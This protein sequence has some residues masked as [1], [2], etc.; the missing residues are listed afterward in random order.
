MGR[1]Y[2]LSL[3]GCLSLATSLLGATA[4]RA[5]SAQEF[6]AKHS[7][8]MIVGTDVGGSFDLMGRLTARHIARH[9][10]GNP[11]IVVTNMPGGGSLLATNH[12]YNVAPRDGTVLGAVVPGIVLTA[13]FK[14]PGARY[15]PTKMHWI[16]NAMDVTAV[17]MLYHTA[18]VK[19]LEGIRKQE[20][21]M[22]A[23]GVSSLDATNAYFL[24]ALIGTK[25]KVVMG[26]KGGEAINLA[27]ERGEIQGRA[28]A[29]WA[30]W[31]VL[32]PDWVRNN[33]IIPLVQITHKPEDDPRLKGVP[34][35]VDLAK[36]DSDRQLARAYTSLVMLGRPVLMGPD[37]PSDRVEV[38]RAAY[39]AML[40]DPEFLAD[41]KKQ[42]VDLNP[43]E[44]HE[45]QN[46][47]SDI[48][49]LPAEQ[50]AKLDAIINKGKS[51][52]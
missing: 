45:L 47:I 39:A 31:K 22:G 19:T 1:T 42:K 3:L 44:G 50:V 17:P 38:I 25:I 15:D 46:M 23:G 36:T 33:Q 21:I 6:Y 29:A 37:V 4:A 27:M 26:Y 48:F 18:P 41:A 35:L 52:K 20:V 51:K 12:I 10:P 30:S 5:E 14:D 9:I 8:R 40:K 43:I 34:L 13:L 28:S 24:N 16:G 49:K 32:R 7:L 11:N 2:S